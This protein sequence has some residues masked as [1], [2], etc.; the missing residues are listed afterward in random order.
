MVEDSS[1]SLNVGAGKN[2]SVVEGS[3]ASWHVSKSRERFRAQTFAVT[4]RVLYSPF[5]SSH[6]Y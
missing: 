6:H 1:F 5:Q 2:I 3:I 4:V